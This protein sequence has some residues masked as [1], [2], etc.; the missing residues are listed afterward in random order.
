MRIIPTA[1]AASALAGALATTVF[2]QTA[3]PPTNPNTKVYGYKK[4]APQ[5]NNPGAS[6]YMGSTTQPR[7]GEAP[8]YGSPKWWE[9]H[10][11]NSNGAGGD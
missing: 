1:L 8:A 9:E 4:T 3:N 10:I 6:T 11:R 7:M 2:G 5:S